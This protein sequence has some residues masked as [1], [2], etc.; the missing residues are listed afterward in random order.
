MDKLVLTKLQEAIIEFKKQSVCA[1]D[2]LKDSTISIHDIE[3][4]TA[5]H[6]QLVLPFAISL[7]SNEQVAYELGSLLAEY[8][9]R[10]M[11]EI[12]NG[13]FENIY[14]SLNRSTIQYVT[15]AAVQAK[16]A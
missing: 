1:Q 15:R 9:H 12:K 7:I 8:N 2:S 5:V 3:K 11:L 13:S 4:A 10:Q 14:A 16:A 6:A